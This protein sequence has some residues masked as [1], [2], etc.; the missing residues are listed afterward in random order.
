MHILVCIS[1]FPYTTPTIK[2]SKLIASLYNAEVTILTVRPKSE[3][4]K[5]ADEIF[6]Q[7]TSIYENYPVHKVISIGEPGREILNTIAWG[8]FDLVIVG[9]HDKPSFEKLFL[10]SVS[11]RI[12]TASPVSVVVVRNPESKIGAILIPTSGFIIMNSAV[13]LGADIAARSKSK[14]TLLHV[15]N[16][17]PSMYSGLRRLDESLSDIL[18]TNSSIARNIREQAEKLRAQGIDTHIE[19]RRGLSVEGI[20]RALNAFDY[21]LLILG[22]KEQNIL[23]RLIS[24]ETTLNIVDHACCP[25]W[26]VKD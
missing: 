25:V 9:A 8:K 13:E 6:D 24:D 7:A 16:T 20:L 5:I 11:K 17:V 19:L 26:I 23:G 4:R 18:Q 14:V 3:P 21:Q 22:G 12:I 10:G 15:T 2:F 1:T